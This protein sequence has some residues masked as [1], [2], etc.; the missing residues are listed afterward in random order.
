MFKVGADPE[1]PKCT[2]NESEDDDST[3]ED[4]GSNMRRDTHSEI[5]T[6]RTSLPSLNEEKLES[7]QDEKSM[8]PFLLAAA[9]GYWKVLEKIAECYDNDRPFYNNDGILTNPFDVTTN[10]TKENAL[11]L[12]LKGP[13][14]KAKKAKQANDPSTIEERV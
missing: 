13:S 1:L 11:H 6:K 4:V 12:I 9:N 7:Y 10:D 5:S 3:S 2:S 8:T 14:L